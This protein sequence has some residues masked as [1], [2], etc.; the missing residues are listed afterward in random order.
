M[1]MTGSDENR[2]QWLYI[3]FPNDEQFRVDAEVIANPGDALAS[4]DAFPFRAN[5]LVPVIERGVQRGH[6]SHALITA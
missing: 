6:V 4:P 2:I 1:G 3:G 5:V